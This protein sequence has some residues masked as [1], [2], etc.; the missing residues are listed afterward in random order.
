MK[1]LE[2]VT[3]DTI[4]LDCMDIQTIRS[5]AIEAGGLD[6][7]LLTFQVLEYSRDSSA[8]LGVALNDAGL[9]DAIE[10]TKLLILKRPGSVFY[11]VP[12]GFVN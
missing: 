3:A 4:L 8:Y 6:P 2:S 11:L 9:P 10:E 1:N 5:E 7:F 12:V